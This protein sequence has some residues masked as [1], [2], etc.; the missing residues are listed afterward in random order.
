VWVMV[1]A[2]N[3]AYAALAVPTHLRMPTRALR[4]D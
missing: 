2:C 4:A 1:V 3:K